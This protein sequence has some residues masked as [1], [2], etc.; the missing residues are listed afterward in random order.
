[1]LEKRRFFRRS[2]NQ[3]NINLC[4]VQVT[5]LNES[6]RQKKLMPRFVDIWKKRKNKL[7]SKQQNL[8]MFQNAPHA[9]RQT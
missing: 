1:M 7:K 5:T 8:S 4:M 6:K 9:A 3:K 2:I